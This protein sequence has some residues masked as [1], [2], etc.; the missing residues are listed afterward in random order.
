MTTR[1]RKEPNMKTLI[2]KMTIGTAA[3]LG[4]GTIALAEDGPRIYSTTA[5]NLVRA[6]YIEPAAPVAY[7][8]A[9]VPRALA[10]Q[11]VHPHM[12]K[13][14]IGLSQAA[15]DAD[16]KSA[17]ITTYID[18]TRRLDANRGLDESHSIVRARANYLAQHNGRYALPNQA[19]LI[20][21]PT[22]DRDA[23]AGRAQ[24]VFIFRKPVE[25]APNKDGELVASADTPASAD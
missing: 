18:P 22:R 8:A 3:V 11:R 12:A 21:R 14:V 1:R 16:H 10:E 19:V 20:I 24:P 15:M 7:P 2:Q 4:L 17:K 25:A 5:P 13:L 9:Q 23:V 6:A